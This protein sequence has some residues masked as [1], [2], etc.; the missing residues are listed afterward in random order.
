M[1]RPKKQVVDY[2]PHMCN[3]KKTIYI[4]EQKYGNNGYAFWFKLLE[5]LGNTEGH[6]LNLNDATT[7]EFLQA[8]THIEESLC[9]EILDLLSKLEAIDSEL[10]EEEKIVWSQNFVDGI[11]DAYKNRRVEIPVKPSFYRQKPRQSEVSTDENPQSKLKETKVKESK[12]NNN[13]YT[14]DFENFWLA[15]P[16]RVEKKRAYSCWQARIKNKA[17]PEEMINA[18]K[19]YAD[20]CR[21]SNT[22]QRYIKHASTFLSDKEDYKDWIREEGEDELKPYTGDEFPELEPYKG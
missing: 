14:S 5:M 19:S 17:D 4:L 8:K 18:A 20:H 3:H 13:I 16:R 22:E 12:L 21:K 11:T 6:F 10:W 2:F 9:T 1:A 15:Y 7:W